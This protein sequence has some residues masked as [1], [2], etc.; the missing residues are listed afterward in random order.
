MRI[1]A[2]RFADRNRASA[3]LG[4]LQRT[5]EVRPPDVAI[6]PLGI[7][8]TTTTNETLLAGRFAEEQTEKVASLVHEAGGE[9][10]V[11]VDERWTRPRHAHK[12]EA[13]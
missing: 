9:I 2:A 6:A 3:V 13:T 1:L 8:G 7:P 10:V 12:V 5:L 4:R 11:N